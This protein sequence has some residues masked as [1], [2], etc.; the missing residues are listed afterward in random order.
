MAGSSKMIRQL[1]IARD[2]ALRARIQAMV[3][4]KTLLV[5]A[6]QALRDRFIGI[7]RMMTLIRVIAALR[8]RS[9]QSEHDQCPDPHVRA[10]PSI[11][12]AQGQPVRSSQSEMIRQLLK[13]GLWIRSPLMPVGS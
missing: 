13:L 7:T 5:N 1:N 11:S 10:V 9:A 12:S 6:Q 3:T 4:L 2:T 8:P